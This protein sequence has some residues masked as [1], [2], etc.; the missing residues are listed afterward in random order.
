MSEQIDKGEDGKREERREYKRA[1]EKTN[2]GWEGWKQEND[3]AERM[4]QVYLWWIGAIT[5]ITVLQQRLEGPNEYKWEDL[6][7]KSEACLRL[8]PAWSIPPLIWDTE[9]L[10]RNLLQGHKHLDA[11]LQCNPE[12]FCCSLETLGGVKRSNQSK[13][14]ITYLNLEFHSHSSVHLARLQSLRRTLRGPPDDVL[15]PASG[16]WPTSLKA[17]RA[18]SSSRLRRGGLENES[19]GQTLTHGGRGNSLLGSPLDKISGRILS[20]SWAA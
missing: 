14:K 12:D 13:K 8:F 19:C 7:P 20:G 6:R 18:S 16:P 1:A 15:R 3:R 10:M 17:F 2:D 9:W 5:T 11:S 4:Q